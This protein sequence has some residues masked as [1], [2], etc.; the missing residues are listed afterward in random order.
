MD[1]SVGKFFEMEKNHSLFSLKTKEG[2]FAWD[3]FR[4]YIFYKYTF[5]EMVLTVA[6]AEI[7]FKKVVKGFLIALLQIPSVLFKRS[8]V[9]IFP[10]SRYLDR[11]GRLYDKVTQDTINTFGK[12]AIVVEELKPLSIYK[13]KIQYNYCSLFARFIKSKPLEKDSYEFL[14][15]VLTCTYGVMKCS[16]TELNQIY[17]D[18]QKEYRFYRF[19]F[20]LKKPKM[21]FYVQRNRVKKGM[22]AAARHVGVKTLEFQHGIFGI[23]HMAYSYPKA[24]NANSSIYFPDYFLTMGSLWGTNVNVPAKVVA[25]GNNEFA[26]NEINVEPDNSLLFIS[27]LIHR[28]EMVALA[29][30]V[31]KTAPTVKI[32]YKLHPNEYVGFDKYVDSFKQYKN[33]QVLCGEQDLK[34]LIKQSQLVV[35]IA[36]TCLFEA[37]NMGQKVAIY[38]KQNYETHL[39]QFNLN[40]VFLFDDVEQLL[41]ITKHKTDSSPQVFFEPFNINI[42]DQ[43]LKENEIY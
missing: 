17:S 18:F 21:V 27:S 41:S 40:N 7:S 37:L 33:I 39:E 9:L 26:I 20:S 34:I 32:N 25:L 23:D 30:R 19:F 11:D 8:E 31:A 6:P 2:L 16:Y 35:L 38:K 22:V 36:S 14:S 4:F 28:D 24:I 43:I 15:T 42:M 29:T 3:I 12:K 10:Y 13:N 1:D 5:P